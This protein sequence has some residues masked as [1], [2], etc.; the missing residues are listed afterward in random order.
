[1]TDTLEQVKD[2]EAEAKILLNYAMALSKASRSART[3]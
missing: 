1:M 3:K 2:A